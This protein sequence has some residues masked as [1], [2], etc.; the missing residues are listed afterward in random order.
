MIFSVVYHRASRV[1]MGVVDLREV[2]RVVEWRR[3]REEDGGKRL[4][5]RRERREA[6]RVAE[7]MIRWDVYRLSLVYLGVA[8]EVDD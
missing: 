6:W 1:V 5:V 7:S 3:R 8:R 4:V 2:R